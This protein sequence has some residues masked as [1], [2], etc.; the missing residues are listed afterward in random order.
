VLLAPAAIVLVLSLTAPS[1]YRASALLGYR[2]PA[3]DREAVR[4][5]G[6]HPVGVRSAFHL[7][8]PLLTARHAP[9]GARLGPVVRGGRSKRAVPATRAVIVRGHD[10]IEVR[11]RATELAR[12]SIRRRTELIAGAAS[13]VRA[14]AS[15]SRRELALLADIER[16]NVFV[17]RPAGPA[18]ASRHPERNI[19]VAAAIGLWLAAVTAL[20]LGRRQQRSQGT[21]GVEDGRLMSTRRTP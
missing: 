7:P 1:G 18:V 9:A 17:R 3:A 4:L 2:F 16:R 14:G 13:R 6:L 11:R 8:D 20:L 10:P 15:G 12:A 21:D 19:A 5:W